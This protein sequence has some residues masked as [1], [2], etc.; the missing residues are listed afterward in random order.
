M[1]ESGA[2]IA[3]HVRGAP[4]EL[5]QQVLRDTEANPETD[6]LP[7]ALA[8]AG[9]S[10]LGRALACHPDILCLDEPLSALDDET[11]DEMIALLKEVQQ[12]TGVTALHIT[13]HRYESERL[14]DHLFRIENGKLLEQ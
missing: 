7:E 5:R 14:A 11:R 8:G 12:K 4:A 13:H 10:A 6:P 3:D 9:W 1:T 2:W